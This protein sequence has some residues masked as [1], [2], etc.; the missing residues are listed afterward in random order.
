MDSTQSDRRA[1]FENIDFLLTE[2]RATIFLHKDM[3]PHKIQDHIRTYQIDCYYAD[4]TRKI[5]FSNTLEGAIE[6][7]LRNPRMKACARG[8]DCLMGPGLHHLDVFPK[9]KDAA[10]GH[11]NVCGKCESKRVAKIQEGKRKRKSIA[12]AGHQDEPVEASTQ[13]KAVVDGH[14]GEGHHH[15]NGKLLAGA[16]AMPS[17][18]SKGDGGSGN[19]GVNSAAGQ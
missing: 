18:I 6:R 8:N 17:G 2:E 7:C 11:M 9:D 19:A 16:I 13:V 14:V 15:V 4:G 12:A 5:E 3:P 1:A 10:D